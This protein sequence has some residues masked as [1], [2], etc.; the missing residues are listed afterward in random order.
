MKNVK[1]GFTLS[2]AEAAF[3]EGKLKSLQGARHYELRNRVKGVL[4]VGGPERLKNEAAAHRC[5]V[6]V[7]TLREWLA[8]YREGGYEGLRHKPVS[9]RPSRLTEV[10]KEELKRI[11][12]E[13]P[14]RL[15]YETGIWTAYLVREVI[16]KRFGVKYSLNNV[17]W[18]LKRLGCSFKMPEKKRTAQTRPGGG[19]GWTLPSPV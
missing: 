18:L 12:K 4:L 15:G 19:S 10:Q 8:R 6:H 14:E 17:Q 7:R 5:K 9:G 16:A 13:S 2:E 11:V 1:K 3:L